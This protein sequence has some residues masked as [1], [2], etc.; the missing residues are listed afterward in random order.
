MRI[1]QKFFSNLENYVDILN[2]VNEDFEV[3]VQTYQTLLNHAIK[4]LKSF[5][6]QEM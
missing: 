1:N 6:L 2:F 3:K 4:M 5:C